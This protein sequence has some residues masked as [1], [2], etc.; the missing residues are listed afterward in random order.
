MAQIDVENAI[1]NEEIVLQQSTTTTTK[2][3]GLHDLIDDCKEMIFEH[4]ELADL[5]NV[6]DTNTQMQ[7]TVCQI[8]ERNHS[9]RRVVIDIENKNR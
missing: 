7:P 5:L 1:A 9:N 4:V 2:A 8:F 3:T 6:A